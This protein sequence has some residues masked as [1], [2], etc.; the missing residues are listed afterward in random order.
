M[1]KLKLNV[2]NCTWLDRDEPIFTLLDAMVDREPGVAS[3]LGNLM[4]CGPSQA[5]KTRIVNSWCERRGVTVLSIQA[6]MDQPEDIGGYPFRTGQVVNYTHPQI[7]PPAFMDREGDYVIF[8]DALDKAPEAVLSCLLTLLSER[9]IRQTKLKPLAVVAAC[10]PP[11]RPLPNPLMA[12]LLWVPY[13]PRDYEVLQRESLSEVKHLLEDIYPPVEE[14]VP[15]L[16]IW[17]GAGHRLASWYQTP[18]FWKPAVQRMVLYGSFPAQKAEAIAHR[19]EEHAIVD[20]VAWA[21]AADASQVRSSLVP[22]LMSSTI[23]VR[24]DIMRILQQKAN[25]DRTGEV[26]RALT[27]WC[28]SPAA[29]ALTDA[30]GRLGG[31]TIEEMRDQADAE[32]ARLE[33]KFRKEEEDAQ[34]ENKSEV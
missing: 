18:E 32:M 33:K 6:Q 22:V 4:L 19:L 14:N 20:G 10:N 25:Q 24:N 11:K 23:P 13:P 16:D 21:R 7:I 3:P 27:A 2:D 34:E 26:A 17:Y 29:Q 30:T 8:L 31:L 5:G 12:R 9:R 15:E 1:T 28:Q